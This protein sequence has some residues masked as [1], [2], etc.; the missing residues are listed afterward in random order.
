MKLSLK[1]KLFYECYSENQSFIINEPDKEMLYHPKIGRQF[2]VQV[3]N[4]L[5]HPIPSTEQGFVAGMMI[6][7]NR[8]SFSGSEKFYSDFSYEDQR[9]AKL[10]SNLLANYI[11]R[12]NMFEASIAEKNSVNFY[13][14]YLDEILKYPNTYQF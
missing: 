9:V 11:E 4:L 3:T 10:C 12:I 1:E 13:L 5:I 6:A 7:F 2:D 14:T 8:R